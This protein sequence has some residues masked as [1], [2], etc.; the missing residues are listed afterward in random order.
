ALDGT[1]GEEVWGYRVEESEDADSVSVGL[2]PDE[3]RV[4][5]VRTEHSGMEA[6]VETVVVDSRT[7][8]VVERYSYDIPVEVM[9]E[10]DGSE[11]TPDARNVPDHTWLSSTENGF[12]ARDITSGEVAWQFEPDAGCSMVAAAGSANFHGAGVGVTSGTYLVPLLCGEEAS[13]V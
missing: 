6:S 12:A 8:D 4:L 5:V 11:A 10:I 3:E 1:S 2:T 9:G 13:P 7:G